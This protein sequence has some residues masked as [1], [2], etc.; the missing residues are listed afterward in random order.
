MTLRG[1]EYAHENH[2]FIDHWH[3][4]RRGNRIIA[5]AVFER[6]SAGDEHRAGVSNG[7]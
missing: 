5:E 4:S 6:L 2:N 7:P 3:P 1:I